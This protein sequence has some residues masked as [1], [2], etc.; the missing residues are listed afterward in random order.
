MRHNSLF[1]ILFYSYFL[2]NTPLKTR[3]I[4][5][6]FLIPAGKAICGWLRK[7]A[8]WLSTYSKMHQQNKLI[9]NKIHRLLQYYSI[10]VL[11]YYNTT[12]LHYYRTTVLQYYSTTVLQYYSTK[13]LQYDRSIPPWPT[14]QNGHFYVFHMASSPHI[15]L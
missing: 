1:K 15:E 5:A 4:I 6:S 3:Q 8:V 10:T 12:V 2:E 11:Q 14:W 13:V 7:Q 9:V